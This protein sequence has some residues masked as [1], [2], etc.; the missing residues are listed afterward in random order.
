MFHGLLELVSCPPPRSRPNANF[1]KPCQWYELWMRIKGPH[2]Y[3]IA[4][5]PLYV[6]RP[7]SAYRNPPTNSM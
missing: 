5:L 6:K 7:S 2:N 4:T 1:G 3:M